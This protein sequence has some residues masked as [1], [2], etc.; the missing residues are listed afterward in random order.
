MPISCT[1]TGTAFK[2]SW[3]TR[4]STW[5]SSSG[6]RAEKWVKSNR[7]LALV[8]QLSRP[9][10]RG[11]PAPSRRAAWSRWAAVWLR[12]MAVRRCSSTLAVTGVAHV[13]GALRHHGPV[14][15]HALGAWWCPPRP[16]RRPRPPTRRCRPPGRRPRRRRGWCPAPRLTSAPS[17][18]AS[19]CWPFWMMASTLP[20]PCI[21]VVAGEHR[22][23]QARGGAALALPG[24]G[25][26]VL[27]GVAGAL[28]LLL[29][30]LRGTAPRPPACPARRGFPWSNPGGSRRCR[31]EV[32]ALSPEN[33]LESALS[34]R[35][36]R[37]GHA[38]VDGLAG[39][40]PPQRR[41]SSGWYSRFSF[42]SG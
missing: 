1:E 9:A 35:S 16:Q 38:L 28:P 37:Q 27:A 15:V 42:S 7:T 32:K 19:T 18:A 23:R 3:L 8:D 17:A 22:L 4:F 20:S 24:V 30:Q 39:S 29:H 33:T 5:C 14:E 41:R 26:G 40:S 31:L 10:P 6:V 25:A 2:I 13:Q 12:M 21:W 34:M 11:C 36:F